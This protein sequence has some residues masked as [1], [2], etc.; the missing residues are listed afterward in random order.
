MATTA[1][2]AAFLND[3]VNKLFKNILNYWGSFL[4]SPDSCYVLSKDPRHGWFGEDAME[5]MPNFAKEFKCN[6]LA[7]HY[8]YTSWDDFFTREFRDHPVPIR[9]V[10]SPNDDYIVANACESAPFQISAAVKNRTSFG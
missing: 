6:P 5:A 1:G 7:E 8:G 2:F 9:P 4:S 10:E 3:K